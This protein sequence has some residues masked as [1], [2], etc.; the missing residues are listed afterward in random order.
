VRADERLRANGS[1]GEELARARADLRRMADDPR[2]IVRDVFVVPGY[3]AH[4][5]LGEHLARA[6]RACVTE[7]RRVV[8]KGH[9]K[10]ATFECSMDVCRRAIDE[11]FGAGAELDFVGVSMGGLL[12]RALAEPEHGGLNIRRLFTISTPHRGANLANLVAPDLA[13]KDMIP[14]SD[15]LHWLDERL[16][17]SP[18]AMRCYARTRDWWVGSE[19]T[20]PTGRSAIV[21]RSPIHTLSH[22]LV[23]RDP[24]IVADIARHLRDEEP[25]FTDPAR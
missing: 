20:A 4:D 19:N 18:Y 12:G 17:R 6:L 7:P 3:R 5:S 25:A 10:C 11:A 9:Q 22:L 24:R 15:R 8:S 21:L 13:A 16:E 2:P 14:G 1:I 23:T